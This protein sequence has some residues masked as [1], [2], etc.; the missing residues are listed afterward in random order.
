MAKEEEFENDM[1]ESRNLKHVQLY[2]DQKI[3]Q[4]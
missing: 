3:F 4:P 1:I 2:V